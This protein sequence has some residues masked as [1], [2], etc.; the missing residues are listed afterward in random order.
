MISQK[1][2]HQLLL[3]KKVKEADDLRATLDETHLLYRDK[4]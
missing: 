3:A 4:V 1:K 2:E